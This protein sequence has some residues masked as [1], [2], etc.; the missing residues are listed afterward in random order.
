MTSKSECYTCYH[1]LFLDFYT[2]IQP[3][4]TPESSDDDQNDDQIQVK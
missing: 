4:P 3:W 1:E 2:K